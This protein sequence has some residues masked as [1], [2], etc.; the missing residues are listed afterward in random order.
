[1]PRT[2]APKPDYA[3]KYWRKHR[4]TTPYANVMDV[5]AKKALR[6]PVDQLPPLSS[7]SQVVKGNSQDATAFAS[8][9]DDFD[10]VITSP[11]Y[12]GMVNYVQDQ[13]LR[14]WFLGGPE[15]PDYRRTDQLDTD[16][17]ASFISALA[18]VWDN[19]AGRLAPKARMFIR[20][21]AIPSYDV[22]PR[23]LLCS[24]LG[25][26]SHDWKVA[27]IRSARSAQAGKRQAALMQPSSSEATV[28]YDVEVRRC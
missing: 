20:F 22:D 5:I 16:G 14:N 27:E 19:V 10:T 4:M 13:W 3:V 2:F 12:Y 25:L 17:P 28:E 6:L 15:K 1:M 11:P 23:E 8:M 21:G 24:S 26:S 18:R 9:P 7:I